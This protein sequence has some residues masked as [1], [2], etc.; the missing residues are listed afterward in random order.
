MGY[1]PVFGGDDEARTATI[2][3]RGAAHARPTILEAFAPTP[4][5]TTLPPSSSPPVAP[6]RRNRNRSLSPDVPGDSTRSGQSILGGRGRRS[7]FL[8]NLLGEENP[9]EQITD[10][11]YEE[12]LLRNQSPN[13]VSSLACHGSSSNS[14]SPHKS[15]S[16]GKSMF[17]GASKYEILEY[18]QDARRRV[19]ISADDDEEVRLQVRPFPYVQIWLLAFI[20]FRHYYLYSFYSDY[21]VLCCIV[22]FF[23]FASRLLYLLVKRDSY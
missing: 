21:F 23:T 13:Y 10:H 15:P 1:V 8:N 12:L 16:P 22:Y 5:S 6:R 17:E 19:A 3:G 18:L 2:R 11:I 4:P 9:Y 20:Q 14:S 7:S